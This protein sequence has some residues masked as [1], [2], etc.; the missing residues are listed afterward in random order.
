MMISDG[1]NVNSGRSIFSFVVVVVV[2]S[3]G[4]SVSV[5]STKSGGDGCGE[6]VSW[7]WRISSFD[8][9][10]EDV[11][12]GGG[13]VCWQEITALEVTPAAGNPIRRRKRE[14]QQV[15]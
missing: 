13:G 2:A 8:D 12:C 1:T 14:G 9:G 6:G 7:V 10:G 15:T 11:D 3:G 4:G 5:Y